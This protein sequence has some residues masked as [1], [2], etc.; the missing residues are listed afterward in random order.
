MLYELR[1]EL[2]KV[3][4]KEEVVKRIEA[5]FEDV[6]LTAEGVEILKID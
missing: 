1:I 2:K 6:G 5:A 3:L 4:S